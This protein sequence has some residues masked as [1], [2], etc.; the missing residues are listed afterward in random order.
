VAVAALRARRRDPA[1]TA[2]AIAALAAWAVHAGVDWDWEMPA[3]TLVAVLLAGMLLA[4]AEDEPRAPP[5]VPA[6]AA[7]AVAAV[8]IVVLVGVGLRAA[9]LTEE[10]RSLVPT[11]A[12][13]LSDAQFEHARSVLRDAQRLT[14]D[15]E[16][17]LLEAVLVVNRRQIGESIRLLDE[18]VD[19]EPRNPQAWA[20]LAAALEAV[21]SPRAAAARARARELAPRRVPP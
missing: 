6:R 4:A 10:G 3:L 15:P 7:V 19:A 2:G 21:R 9:T 5:P 1:L 14:P 20:L 16:P 18:V 13:R 11:R 12:V 17:K 8:A